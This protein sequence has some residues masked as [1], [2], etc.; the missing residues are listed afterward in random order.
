MN[1]SCL[2]RLLWSRSLYSQ[3]VVPLFPVM[4]LICPEDYSP[5][6]AF[7]ELYAFPNGEMG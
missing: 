5:V 2:L 7:E 3:A 6:R 1:R 4:P